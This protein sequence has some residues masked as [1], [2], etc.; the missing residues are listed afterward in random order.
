[1][2]LNFV[3]RWANKLAHFLGR[4]ISSIMGNVFP[5]SIVYLDPKIDKDAK[6][7]DHLFFTQ[8]GKQPLKPLPKPFSLLFS[9][10]VLTNLIPKQTLNPQ[11]GFS[12]S[13]NFKT[14]FNP[15]QTIHF[16]AFFFHT[17][18]IFSYSSL[19]PINFKAKYVHFQ[20]PHFNFL[21]KIWFLTLFLDFQAT[22]SNGC[23]P[24]SVATPFCCCFSSIDV[25][26]WNRFEGLEIVVSG[27][28][29]QCKPRSL[30]NFCNVSISVSILLL[31]ACLLRSLFKVAN[32]ICICVT[33][34]A[35][36]AFCGCHLI[37]ML[38]FSAFLYLSFDCS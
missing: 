3:K 16:Q 33:M 13:F 25:V 27:Y 10:C 19:F 14:N 5:N 18:F 1:M 31:F 34:L 32:F 9:F 20:Q 8:T 22:S 7:K 24:V 15:F 21:V 26:P 4:Q 30:I 17:L 6:F 2:T 12:I 37:A 36:S 38:A 35:F 23:S 11:N 28:A 29:L